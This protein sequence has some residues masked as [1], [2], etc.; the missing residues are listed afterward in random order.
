MR[1]V[2][3]LEKLTQARITLLKQRLGCQ[4]L[5]NRIGDDNRNIKPKKTREE[6][7]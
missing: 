4:Y 7:S 3:Q 5:G 2:G 1:I 6:A